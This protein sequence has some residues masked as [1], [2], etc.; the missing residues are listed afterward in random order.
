MEEDKH[1]YPKLQMDISGTVNLCDQYWIRG[2]C[3]LEV[4]SR[5]PSVLPVSESLLERLEPV[6]AVIPNLLLLAG[7]ER[8]ETCEHKEHS[9][10]MVL[11]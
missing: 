7:L 1:H 3:H 10:R 2:P 6:A 8:I 4:Q 9:G 5:V 11:K